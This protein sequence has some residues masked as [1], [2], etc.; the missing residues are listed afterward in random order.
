[1][2]PHLPN[3][4]LFSTKRISTA[5]YMARRPL[6][7]TLDE[8]DLIQHC[9]PPPR[10]PQPCSLN[11]VKKLRD[12]VGRNMVRK[13]PVVSYDHEPALPDQVNRCSNSVVGNVV[14]Q[15]SEV[16]FRSV[17]DCEPW[18]FGDISRVDAER[19]L[20]T[21]GK[22]GDY[23]VRESRRMANC[24]T[25]TVKYSDRV[26]HFPVDVNK[27]KELTIGKV[28]FPNMMD[29]IAFYKVNALCHSNQRC[30]TLGD[31]LSKTFYKIQ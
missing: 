30:V 16:E 13:E 12:N 21:H 5:E 4:P 24:Y 25:L 7:P 29:V 26:L 9:E 20:E 17:Y 1:M 3:P 27:D 14:R 8:R 6:P 15:K 22:D 23:L 2:H 31:C 11:K 28:T 19:I 10:P 18:Y